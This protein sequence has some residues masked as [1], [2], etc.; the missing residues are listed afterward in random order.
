MLSTLVLPLLALLLVL[1]ARAGKGTSR[2]HLNYGES[3]PIFVTGAMVFRGTFPVSV[4]LLGTEWAIV[5][6]ALAM[7][8]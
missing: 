6:S 1:Y 2:F 7:M 5:P 4:G 8:V 3:E